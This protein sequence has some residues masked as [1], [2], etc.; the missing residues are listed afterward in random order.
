MC[1]QNEH[2]FVVV[3]VLHVNL[4]IYHKTHKANYI[5]QDLKMLPVSLINPC[6]MQFSCSQNF[7][8]SIMFLS[9]RRKESF[10]SYFRPLLSFH[11]EFVMIRCSY[12]I[13]HEWILCVLQG[14]N[15]ES[16]GH[17]LQCARCRGHN[18]QQ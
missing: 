6:R 5:S 13:A 12:E 9:Q 3:D 15:G 4:P 7:F 17:S 16:L 8:C 2:C 18:R 10:L 14:H 11:R 1:Y